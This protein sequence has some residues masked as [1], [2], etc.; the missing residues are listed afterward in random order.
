VKTQLHRTL[1]SRTITA[2]LALAC[3]LAA[4][5]AKAQTSE[6]DWID[7]DLPSFDG[8]G[9][10]PSS[11]GA[12]TLPPT[13]DPVYYVTLCP[14]F[15]T[16]NPGREGPVMVRFVPGT[17]IETAT[18]TWSA[19]NLGT[20]DGTTGG[21]KITANERI[22]FVRQG[23]EIIR[24][25]MA[26]NR[27]THWT[28]ISTLDLASQ[29]DLALIERKSGTKYYTD[30][31]TTHDDAVNNG[32][33]QRLT[34]Q[35]GSDSASVRRWVVDAG[36]GAD[37][38][39]GVAYFQG[40]I[41][42]SDAANISELNPSTNMVRRWSLAD[43]FAAGGRQ[44]S[45]DTK[46]VVWAVTAT[47]HIVSLNP[48]TNQMAS[49]VIPGAGAPPSP[50]IFAQP[51]GIGTSGGIVGFT[52][53]EGKKVGLLNPNATTITVTPVVE[54]DVPFSDDTLLGV[55]D[56]MNRDEGFVVPQHKP[57]Q[58]A[59]HTD[60]A[61]FGDF[62]EVTTPD[63]GNFPL[64]IFRDVE[65]AIG[66]FYLV[67]MVG[68]TTDHRLSHVSFDLSTVA[69]AGLVTGGGT[70]KTVESTATLTDITEEIIEPDADAWGATER[71]NFGFN[72]YRKVQDGPVRGHLNYLNKETGEHVKSVQVLTLEVVGNTAEFSGSC[73]VRQNN[74]ETPCS[75]IVRV[76]D[77]GNPGKGNDV[78]EI[79]GIGVIPNGGVLTG[80]NIKIR[81]F[82]QNSSN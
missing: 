41:Y 33:V 53:S 2:G 7:W 54:D 52:E 32:I 64:G 49:Y 35:N 8:A 60:M 27:L 40:K 20:I 50:G 36:A 19:W 38:L 46:G 79:E 22:A 62:I 31:Y 78:F 44:I 3:V 15:T 39:S 71:A 28:D 26:T 66:N 56:P 75:F 17:P 6:A 82:S 24:V 12:V 9:V 1:T 5:P 23:R 55:P 51:F 43:V 73:V 47:G 61:P 69:S 63:T 57:G 11:I 58:T 10:C 48:A 30:V 74:L 80:G 59:V 65:R 45:V 25:D 42:F 14:S 68:G 34:V 21:M 13:G 67:Q 4:M 29:S 72:V 77:N 81:Q 76:Q 16:T 18:A 70:I 37:Y